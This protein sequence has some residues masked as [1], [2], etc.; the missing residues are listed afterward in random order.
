MMINKD[1]YFDFL[2]DCFDIKIYAS[3]MENSTGLTLSVTIEEL[4]DGITFEL[5]NE[6]VTGVKVARWQDRFVVEP[7]HS[8]KGK[9]MY[10][11]AIKE[12]MQ[13]G[14]VDCKWNMPSWTHKKWHEINAMTKFLIR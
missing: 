2:S 11:K 12:A 13:L 3:V 9:Y 8:I 14:Y 5:R 1:F 4:K 6:L 7:Y 10:W